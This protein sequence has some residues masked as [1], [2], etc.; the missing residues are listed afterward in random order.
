MIV[1][2]SDQQPK[3]KISL[4]SFYHFGHHYHRFG[5]SKNL[6]S[7]SECIWSIRFYHKKNIFMNSTM[8]DLAIPPKTLLQIADSRRQRPATQ[9]TLSIGLPNCMLSDNG[10][11]SSAASFWPLFFSD[12]TIFYLNGFHRRLVWLCSFNFC[13]PFR[14]RC[15]FAASGREGR[16]NGCSLFINPMLSS[17]QLFGPVLV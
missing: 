11:T 8:R 17:R 12:C 3:V 15:H 10:Q 4:K 1:A 16:E 7:S 2:Q 9:S 13:L 6:T 5:R 14:S